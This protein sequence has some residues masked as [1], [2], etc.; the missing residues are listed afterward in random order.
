MNRIDKSIVKVKKE[1]PT[2]EVNVYCSGTRKPARRRSAAHQEHLLR[3]R[4]NRKPRKEPRIVIQLS[5]SDSSGNDNLKSLVRC[6]IAAEDEE[7]CL[8]P[9]VVEVEDDPPLS[10]PISNE[11]SA[12]IA[13][14]DSPP[15][16]EGCP[17]CADLA[18]APQ[19]VVLAPMKLQNPPLPFC[20][21]PIPRPLHVWHVA[22]C[23][24]LAICDAEYPIP[25]PYKR[26]Y[27]EL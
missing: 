6:V 22:Q 11:E 2:T 15:E 26:L 3:R 18:I 24:L 10:L 21:M 17:L 13:R 1:T 14:D 16:V 20:Y 7:K 27:R 23:N 8:Y 9:G 5:E 25:S 19:Q 12:P 4:A